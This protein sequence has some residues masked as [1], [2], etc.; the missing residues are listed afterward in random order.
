VLT[1]KI[2][3]IYGDCNRFDADLDEIIR[4]LKLELRIG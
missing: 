3:K 4:F 2:G 1:T